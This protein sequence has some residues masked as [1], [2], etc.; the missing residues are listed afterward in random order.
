MIKLSG[1]RCGTETGTTADKTVK[2]L[3]LARL[4]AGI[5]LVDNVKT[6]LATHDLAV[7][8]TVFQRFKRAADFHDL[9]SS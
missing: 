2:A 8:M 6:A 9:R 1:R 3:T 4:K 5:R 7:A